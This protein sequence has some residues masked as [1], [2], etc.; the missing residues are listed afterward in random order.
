MAN[1]R[2]YVDIAFFTK[3]FIKQ[4]PEVWITYA[5]HPCTHHVLAHQH[6]VANY[7]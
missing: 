4:Q 7:T 2:A 1:N 5:E 6:S 3:R